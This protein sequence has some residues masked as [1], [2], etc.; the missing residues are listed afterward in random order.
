MCQQKVEKHIPTYSQGTF[1]PEMSMSIAF[2]MELGTTGNL[3]KR[4]KAVYDWTKIWFI[5]FRNGRNGKSS[6]QETAS[7]IESAMNLLYLTT[8]VAR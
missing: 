7:Y 8:I 1:M 6:T 2:K 5:Q 3:K 4:K